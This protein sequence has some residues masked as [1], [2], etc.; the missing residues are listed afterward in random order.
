MADMHRPG[1][2]GGDV[3]DVDGLTLADVAPAIVG[4]CFDHRAQLID[5]DGRPEREIDEAGP[6]DLDFSSSAAAS[7]FCSCFVHI[8]RLHKQSLGTTNPPR[9]ARTVVPR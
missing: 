9:Y 7:H 8:K 2:I 4:A 3:F 1:G 6:R 5:P